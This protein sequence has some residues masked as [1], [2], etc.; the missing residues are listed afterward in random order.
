MP[1]D[2]SRYHPDW[3]SIRRQI[4][5]QANH[6]CEFC[7]VPNGVWVNRDAGGR[8]TIDTTIEPDA[9]VVGWGWGKAP[10]LPTKIVLTIAHLDHDTSNNDPCNLR[11][12]C[13]QCHLRWDAKHHQKNAAETRRQKRLVAGQVEMPAVAS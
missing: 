11:A 10:R 2:Y 7:G 4:L 12:L 6:C 13:Q 1:C 8:W 5:D 3:K 9:V